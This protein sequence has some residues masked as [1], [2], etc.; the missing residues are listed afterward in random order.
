MPAAATTSYG[1]P[2]RGAGVLAVVRRG[3]L[4]ESVHAGHL[5]AADA[6]GRT[7]VEVGDP[8]ATLWPRST[9][10]PVQAVAMLRHGLALPDRLLALA[11]ASHSG[12]EAHRDGVLEILSTYGLDER[13]L[14]NEPTLPLDPEIAR[15]WQQAGHGPERLT[16]NC[17]GKH[18]AMLA[19][20]VAAGW[21]TS[22]YLAVDHPLQVALR[23][24]VR[25]LTAPDAEAAGAPPEE[26]GAAHVTVDGCGAPL[27]SAS[28]A[29]LLRAFRR[30]ATAPGR[31]PLAPEALVARAM[32]QHP[33][34]V[35]GTRRETTLLMDAVPGMVVKDGADGVLAAALPDGRA[36]A[37][38]IADGGQR[39]LAAVATAV[40]DRL[41]VDVAGVLPAWPVEGGGRPVGRVEAALPD[42]PGALPGDAA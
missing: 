37:L 26:T 16:Q 27:F 23:D 38:K 3:D 24:V 30:I 34:M 18:A 9:L 25:E 20:C 42:A 11:C 40:L 39:P 10:K 8:A 4:V 21:P 36:F 2:G 15:E 41:G 33:H 28:T 19:T 31:D 32:T 12:D 13:A 22:G 1:L 35:A 6:D 29:G 14:A 17:S 5:R 7:V